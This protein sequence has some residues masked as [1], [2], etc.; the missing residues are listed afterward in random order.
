MIFIVLALFAIGSD[1]LDLANSSYPIFKGNR[2][3]NNQI[4]G[5]IACS[6][7]AP[8][9]TTI[10]NDTWT[11]TDTR[12]AVFPF[13]PII[14][15]DNF[16]AVMDFFGSNFIRQH[17]MSGAFGGDYTFGTSVP[18]ILKDGSVA[19]SSATGT[20]LLDAFLAEL[21]SP[22]PNIDDQTT[23]SSLIP[24]QG[25]FLLRSGANGNDGWISFLNL[26]NDVSNAYWAKNITKPG[27]LRELMVDKSSGAD[28]IVGVSDVGEGVSIFVDSSDY[29]IA[30]VNLH[31]DVDPFIVNGVLYVFL[32]NYTVVSFNLASRT[33]TGGKSWAANRQLEYSMIMRGSKAL[34]SFSEPESSDVVMELFSNQVVLQDRKFAGHPTFS[35][36]DNAAVMTVADQDG[37]LQLLAL[38]WD[39]W[40]VKATGL[41]DQV[42]A[43]SL[44]SEAVFDNECN[45]FVTVNNGIIHKFEPLPIQDV[46]PVLECI[47]EFNVAY[48]SYINNEGDGFRIPY[49]VDRNSL[50]PGNIAPMTLFEDVSGSHYPF[51]TRLQLQ[52]VSATYEW[53]LED[54]LLTFK[55][56]PQTACPKNIT[57]AMTF[58]ALD[59]FNETTF[60]HVVK[61]VFVALTG[62]REERVSVGEVVTHNNVAKR[63]IKQGSP[64]LDLELEVAAGNDE[65]ERTAAEIVKDF[66][67][68]QS[69]DFSQQIGNNSES[70]A[71]TQVT[72]IAPKYPVNSQ[73]GVFSPILPPA[74]EA[75]VSIPEAPTTS[76]QSAPTKTNDP[77]SSGSRIIY[78]VVTSGIAIVLLII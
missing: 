47:D 27:S 11:S 13:P 36:P 77:T 71:E 24:Y 57:I 45:V 20:V 5:R 44:V 58:I 46:V 18:T 60:P 14:G 76:P 55:I 6:W 54:Y 21:L 16:Y 26:T 59:M 65:T 51:A 31:S 56:T 29:N 23:L 49:V 35:I 74:P 9:R 38:E 62:V 72:N 2:E 25:S 12:T 50:S 10:L 48:F 63:K 66:V 41:F 68:N 43:G 22:I 53:R 75:P 4:D 7:I 17:Y 67:E 73:T 39:T 19:L 69:S 64:T 42:P 1:S 52:N 15:Q 33:F 8:G 70:P 40:K 37:E 32:S 30:G 34:A 3:R 28:V 78:T 61:A